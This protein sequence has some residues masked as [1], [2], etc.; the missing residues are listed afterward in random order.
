MSGLDP[1]YTTVEVAEHF[2]VKPDTVHRWVR[3]KRITAIN[4]GGNRRG[5]YLFRPSDVEEFERNAEQK[6]AAEVEEEATA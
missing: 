6:R 2:R 5:P 1:R 4:L 3:E